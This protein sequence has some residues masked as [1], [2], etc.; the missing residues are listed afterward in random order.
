MFNINVNV[1][2]GTVVDL[3]WYCYCRARHSNMFNI[4]VIIAAGTGVDLYWYCYYRARHSNM[5]NINVNVAAGTG[6]EFHLTYQQL[7]VR[8]HGYYEHKI[9]V[10]LRQKIGALKI[11]V[12]IEENR[13]ITYLSTPGLASDV[14]T[15]FDITGEGKGSNRGT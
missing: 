13:D 1:A 12:Y 9:H 5:F 10:D 11:E 2:A 6:V 8:S 4:N 14:L 7:L 15:D 3:Y